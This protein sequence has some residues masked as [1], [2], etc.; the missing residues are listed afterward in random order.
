[1]AR[2]KSDN[3]YQFTCKVTGETV[4]TNPKQFEDLSKRYGITPEELDNS[5]VSRAGRHTISDQGLSPEQAVE[6]YGIHINVAN[7][8]KC[9]VKPKPEKKPRATK[10]NKTT[11]AEQLD[12]EP[13]KAEQVGD[14]SQE[15]E[16]EASSQVEQTEMA[17]SA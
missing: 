12:G 17:V 2:P 16:V 7:N 3:R 6:K 13:I 10:A 11:V 14:S 5:Y 8:L 1:M 15:Q 9:T 4:K